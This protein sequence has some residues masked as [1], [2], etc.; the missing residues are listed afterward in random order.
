MCSCKFFIALS[1]AY[2]TGGGSKSE[3]S[4]SMR[5]MVSGILP[6]AGLYPLGQL[7]EW[8]AADAIT[9]GL[10]DASSLIGGLRLIKERLRHQFEGRRQ[11]LLKLLIVSRP[12]SSA[13]KG[14]LPWV[15]IT[16]ISERIDMNCIGKIRVWHHDF[17]R[18]SAT[19]GLPCRVGIDAVSV[20]AGAI[21]SY[22][23]AKQSFRGIATRHIVSGV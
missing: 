18:F 14:R 15:R 5:P 16:K 2:G 6:V 21:S 4:R 12:I 17:A 10:P 22:D 19:S 7:S 13:I 1:V 20:K 8:T 3:T 23:S 9:N 11:A